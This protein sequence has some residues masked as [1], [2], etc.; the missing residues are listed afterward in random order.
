MEFVKT[1]KCGYEHDKVVSVWRSKKPDARDWSIFSTA[2]VEDLKKLFKLIQLFGNLTISS[3]CKYQTIDFFK[4]VER[5]I[6]RQLSQTTKDEIVNFMLSQIK[7]YLFP[8]IVYQLVSITTDISFKNKTFR[9]SKQ[10]VSSAE[11][12]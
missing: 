11:L 12:R 1:I 2:D 3:R 9:C 7:T 10:D 6:A 4:S 5:N 8:I